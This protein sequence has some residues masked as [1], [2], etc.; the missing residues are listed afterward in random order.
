MPSQTYGFTFCNKMKTRLGLRLILNVEM[1]KR[2]FNLLVFFSLYFSLGINLNFAFA[3]SES[4]SKELTDD[5]YELLN[6]TYHRHE[7]DE[8]KLYHQ[9]IG[10]PSWIDRLLELK[11]EEFLLLYKFTDEELPAVLDRLPELG[12]ELSAKF[13]DKNKLSSKTKLKRKREDESMVYIAEPIIYSNYAFVLIRKPKS[14]TVYVYYR[15]PESGWT[16]E[17]VIPLAF[18][19]EC[20]FG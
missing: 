2:P 6:L 4:T 10:D 7:N 8:F 18:V 16:E 12:S 17:C 14:E 20:Y 9:S 11:S 15:N 1:V 3:Q 5:Q 19:I 13:L